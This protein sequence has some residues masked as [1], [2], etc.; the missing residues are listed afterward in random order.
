M[1][2][3]EE[4]QL[5]PKA[6]TAFNFTRIDTLAEKAPNTSIDIVGIISKCEDVV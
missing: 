5:I 6:Y 4:D 2:Q 1:R 3:M